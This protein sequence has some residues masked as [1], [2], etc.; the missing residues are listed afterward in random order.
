MPWSVKFWMADSIL[1]QN[2]PY[3]N[4]AITCGNK[5]AS[6]TDTDLYGFR[7]SLFFFLLYKVSP[8]FI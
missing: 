3:L 4:N 1:R 2:N 7:M 6:I 8:F 5:D